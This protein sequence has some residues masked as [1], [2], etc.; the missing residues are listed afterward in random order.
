MR[1][2][3]AIVA[4]ITLLWPALALGQAPAP[5]SA[6]HAAADTLVSLLRIEEAAAAGARASIQQQVAQNPDLEAYR[7]ILEAWSQKHLSG[8]EFRAAVVSL[9]AE[10]F[11]APELRDLIAFY[12]SRTGQKLASVQ[13]TLVARSAAIGQQIAA[14]NQA[15]LEAA[16]EA[17]NAE[18]QQGKK[19]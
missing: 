19:D 11:A 9:Y 16:V 13:P 14:A 3:T 8:P 7:D 1:S 15:E 12:R 10:T 6:A 2:R 17:R 4:T 18:L 5:R